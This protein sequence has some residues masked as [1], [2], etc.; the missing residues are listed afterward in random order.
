MESFFTNLIVGIVGGELVSAGITLTAGGLI[1]G[2]IPLSIAEYFYLHQ[3]KLDYYMLM[4]YWMG[5]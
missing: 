2:D 5:K 3:E 4:D 1:T